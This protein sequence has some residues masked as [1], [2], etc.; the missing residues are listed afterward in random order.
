MTASRSL[1]AALQQFGRA[2]AAHD[3][4]D[5]S[6]AELVGRFAERRDEVAFTALVRRYGPV[7]F[8]VCRRVLRHDHDAEDAF[9][10]TFLVLAQKA[11]AVR[12]AGAVGNWLY[13]VAYN[14]A[15]KAKARRLERAVREGAV[16]PLRTEAAP[17][18]PDDLP[19]VVDAEL[20]A[21]P[22]RYRT[23]VVLCDLRGLTIREAAAEVGCPAKTLG[24]RLTRGRALLAQRLTR[25]GVTLGAA[26][27]ATALGPAAADAA[28][29]ARLLGPTVD[30]A[31]ALAAGSSSAISPTVLALTEGV[32][33]FMVPK[34]LKCAALLTCA[35]VLLAG[36]SAGAHGALT[37]GTGAPVVATAD[38]VPPPVAPRSTPATP[39]PAENF[40]RQLHRF[41]MVMLGPIG[42]THGEPA[43]DDAKKEKAALKGAWS[44]K[45]GEQ[46]IEFKDKETMT[47]SAH[48]GDLVVTCEYSLGKDGQVKAKLIELS[49]KEALK[50]K[51]KDKLPI[52]LEFR[53][54]WKVKGAS[55]TLD[56]L[57]GENTEILKSHLEGEYE[58]K[59]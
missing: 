29:L 1:S 34:T 15:R 47:I 44:R 24:T 30:A 8:R 39:T 46:A 13:G 25:R 51:A 14:V 23:A 54:T 17:A 59:K 53:F 49:G 55:A 48:N 56:D 22:D 11:S 4:G 18:L 41:F 9:Q 16:V 19:E 2:L 27:L 43:A 42:L 37:A 12:Q 32:V 52:G 6:D 50:E 33:D 40:H 20:S 57:T 45:G 36:L 3:L 58:A 7:V 21:L 26:A 5:A 38:E 35:A 31:A 10:A 28:P